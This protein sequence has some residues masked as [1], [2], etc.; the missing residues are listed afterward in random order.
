MLKRLSKFD[1][2]TSVLGIMALAALVFMLCWVSSRF[3][4]LDDLT[5]RD[6]FRDFTI[7]TFVGRYHEWSQRF[8]IEYIIFAVLKL[9]SYYL[10]KL[11]TLLLYV[12]YFFVLRSIARKFVTVD[13]RV[14]LLIGLA[15]YLQSQLELE[16]AGYFT[17]HMNY[18]APLVAIL[19]CFKL[20]LTRMYGIKAIAFFVL[21]IF[22]T[23]NEML[24]AGA[25]LALPYF[26]FKA[27]V[28]NRS[29]VITALLIAII[30]LA[31]F[32]NSGATTVRTCMHQAWVFPNF[33][34]L[35]FFYK[36]YLGDLTTL[37][38]YFANFNPF[39][40]MFMT[41]L[42]YAYFKSC[43]REL[44]VIQVTAIAAS[45]C[46][47]LYGLGFL[48]RD[49]ND[50]NL[51]VVIAD[52]I[53]FTSALKVSLYVFSIAVSGL[54][55]YMIYRLKGE[56]VNSSFKTTLYV[57]LALAFVIRIGMGFSPTILFSQAR[58]F[59]FSN[60]IILLCTLYIAFK[61]DL[62]RLKQ[63]SVLTLVCVAVCLVSRSSFLLSD[64]ADDF[65]YYPVLINS[66]DKYEDY[67]YIKYDLQDHSLLDKQLLEQ[68]KHEYPFEELK[69]TVD[70]RKNL[71]KNRIEVPAP[72]FN[73]QI[74]N[75]HSALNRELESKR[76]T[77]NEW[78]E[79]Q[80][81]DGKMILKVRHLE[82]QI[83]DPSELP[84]DMLQPIP[85]Q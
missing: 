11:I 73:I 82:Q 21:F 3:I 68:R 57:M 38:Y 29:V 34:D 17:T 62:Y 70:L 13:V 19:Y 15:V 6:V 50:S 71:L 27:P 18:L 67:C 31:L 60:A 22:A 79:N 37:L 42:V 58:T 14:N 16:G 40:V 8:F 26:F 28:K 52:Y 45:L 10:P 39:T 59:I 61:F 54:I 63:F 35:S 69:A 7:H 77:Y 5:Y 32:F 51:K 25:I 20:L 49:L 80:V 78:L 41:T 83:L 81:K 12:A 55:A 56:S 85:Q 66:W 75:G 72:I 24:A 46:V 44:T 9:D 84:V 64:E 2:E 53:D 76:M 36:I 48:N 23:N 4:T 1:R 74:S 43:G 30:S 65:P 47:L 33:A